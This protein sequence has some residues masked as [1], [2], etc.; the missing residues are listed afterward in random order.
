MEM[1]PSNVS[2]INTP[3]ARIFRDV[4]LKRKFRSLCYEAQG[5]LVK[6]LGLCR[7][8][9]LPFLRLVIKDST[10][11]VLGSVQ[12]IKEETMERAKAA[13]GWLVRA[14]AA[15]VDGGVSYGY[16][17][18]GSGNGWKK[19]YPETTGYIMATLL[20][21]AKITGDKEIAEAAL[22]MA[23]WEVSVQMKSGA[24]QAN[25]L[26]AQNNQVA[27]AFNTG[28]VLDGWI[29]AF[30]FSQDERF[31]HAGKRAGDFLVGDV[32]EQGYL[33]SQGKRTVFFPIKTYTCLC[34]WHLCR[35]SEE[36]EDDRYRITA[37]KIVEAALKQ[38]H[39]N[40]W[41]ANNCLTRPEAP[42]L[43]TIGYTLQGILEVGISTKRDDFITAVQRGVDP[44]IS[45]MSPQGFLP[46]RF[47]SDWKPAGF[48]S[49]LTG[50]AQIAVVCYRLF[51]HTENVKYL[52]AA[53]SL[54]NFLKALQSINLPITEVHGAIPGSFP[55][56][57]AYQMLGYPNWAT[58]YYLDALLCQQ[59]LSS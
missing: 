31:L 33:Q 42:L 21:Y 40:G 36:I 14:Q 37:V 35:L 5:I 11:F 16:F 55:I 19:S 46:G 56:V 29:E 12:P 49:C 2:T 18:Y 15:T 59:R 23:H 6:S 53:D 44:L 25:E 38:Q 30:R 3:T 4:L 7:I 8:D 57:G 54:V 50:S 32:D 52:E 43:H 17:P 51:E 10:R 24:V 41:F 1:F 26:C 45:K 28:M 47:Y 27:A 22:R 20:G 48:S 34:A 13:V 39:D 58:K 9:R